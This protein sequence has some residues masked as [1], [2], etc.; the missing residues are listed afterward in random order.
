MSSRRV[1][2]TGLA[3]ITPVGTGVADFWNALLEA[4]SGIRRI[5]SFDPA[6]F[7]SQIGG[8]IDEVKIGDHVPKSYR[9]AGKIMARDIVLAI[10]AAHHAVTDAG[11]NT[12]CI[13]ER[14]EAQERNI[15]SARLGANI[16]A[17]LICAD[18]HELAEALYSATEDGNSPRSGS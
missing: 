2:I 16:G 7:E 17:G 9:K 6:R 11:I 18:L 10:A 15:D 13:V 14:G 1:V 12:K 4:K 3:P 8:E 5:R